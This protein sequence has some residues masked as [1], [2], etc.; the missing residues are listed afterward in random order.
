MP[1][2]APLHGRTETTQPSQFI[3]EIPGHL[4]ERGGFAATRSFTPAR[5]ATFWQP[6]A[7]SETS[8][9]PVEPPKFTIGDRVEHP[10]FGEGL[11]VDASP[12]GEK[13][14]WVHVAFL[15]TDVGKKRLVVAY[16]PLEKIA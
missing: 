12:P 15:K 6:S 4:L 2:N 16:A 3:E 8:S 5:A 14:E 9:A 13:N 11:V 1:P 10:S 7:R